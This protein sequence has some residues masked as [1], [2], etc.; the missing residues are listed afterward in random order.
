MPSAALRRPPAPPA[1]CAS[2]LSASD[3]PALLAADAGHRHVAFL[4][5]G[6]AQ[7]V[8]HTAPVACVMAAT[9]GGLRPWFLITDAALAPILREVEAV[10]PGAAPIPIAL[11][12]PSCLARWLNMIRY[13]RHS[14]KSITLLKNRRLLGSFDALVTAER[15]STVLRKWGLK[16]PR[17]IHIPHGAG[18]RKQGF[19]PRIRRFDLTLLGGRKDADRMLSEGLIRPGHYAISGYIKRDFIQRRLRSAPPLFDNGRPTVLYNPHF[20]RA[21]SSWP[22]HG[23]ELIDLFAAQDQFNL[24]VAPHVRLF[25]E[26]PDAERERWQRLAVPGRILI[27]LGSARSIDASY[28]SGCD[29]YLGDVSSQVY[30]FVLRPRPCVFLNSFRVDWAHDPNY[31]HWKMGRVI[32]QPD[33]LM[34]AL[35]Q[36]YSGF[37][38]F[39]PIQAAAVLAAL[40]P[41]DGQAPARAAAAIAEYLRCG[42]LPAV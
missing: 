37:E 27:D 21:L 16:T 14:R 32:E 25:K 42:Q 30:E 7:H 6:E 35:R 4:F 29:I 8:A 38:P 33:S 9:A 26:A 23:R 15:T 39:R 36:A 28:T 22:R 24:V 3:L 31:A 1:S 41:D 20:D 12:E 34:E 11:L 18:D 19:D 10:Y 2:L 40:G 17:M 13:R 5:L